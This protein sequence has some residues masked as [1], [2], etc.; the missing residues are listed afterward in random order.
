MFA[1]L[2]KP[3]AKRELVEAAARAQWKRCQPSEPLPPF[4]VVGVRGYYRDTMGQSGRNDRGIYDDAIFIVGPDTFAPF[5]ANTDPSIHRPGIASLV[6]GCHPYRPG[7]HG[8]SRG[9]GYPAFRPATPGE[10]LPVTRDGVTDPKPGIA[11]NIHRGGY[12]TTSSAG[13]Q[14]LQPSDWE[15]FHALVHVELR[16]AGIRRFWYVLIDGPIV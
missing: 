14:T 16:R 9:T 11:I 3:K 15:A 13:C 8:I 4:Y 10:A 12:T 2:R 6:T 1:L 7:R 5:R